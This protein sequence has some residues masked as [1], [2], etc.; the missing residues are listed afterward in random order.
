MI[1]DK[2]YLIWDPGKIPTNIEHVNHS[3]TSENLF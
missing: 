2:H 3:V 1:N